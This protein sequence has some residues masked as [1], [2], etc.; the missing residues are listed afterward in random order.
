M[1]E[2]D[3]LVRDM[4]YTR[5]KIQSLQ[6]CH[7]RQRAALK[8]LMNGDKEDKPLPLFEGVV[9][10]TTPAKVEIVEG[11]PKSSTTRLMDKYRRGWLNMI[12]QDKYRHIVEKP[13]RND[14]FLRLW[15]A[16]L[17]HSHA[18]GAGRIAIRTAAIL[19][20]IHSSEDGHAAIIKRFEWLGD[21]RLNQLAIT[22]ALL[23]LAD[24]P[25][26]SDVREGWQRLVYM[27][28]MDA[29]HDV[30]NGT[31]DMTQDAIPNDHPYIWHLA[32]FGE[33]MA[34]RPE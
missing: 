28:A 13:W 24:M 8:A 9:N 29:F 11:N 20:M 30:D 18:R 14:K 15:H 21:P 22:P 2:I 10:K 4:A 17:P 25:A 23:A 1:D 6:E 34:R 5:R 27:R 32:G 31:K 19:A 12:P 3:R 26:R 7:D 33:L 16:K